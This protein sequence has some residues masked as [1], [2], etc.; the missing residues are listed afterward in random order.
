[1][2]PLT[3]SAACGYSLAYWRDDAGLEHLPATANCF[4]TY[5]REQWVLTAVGF[6]LLDVLFSFLSFSLLLSFAHADILYHQL[7]FIKE[8]EC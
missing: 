5:Q 6:S 7:F 4:N 3:A 1:M 2:V 8:F